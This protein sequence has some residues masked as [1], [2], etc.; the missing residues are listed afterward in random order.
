MVNPMMG[1][2]VFASNT[3][4]PMLTVIGSLMGHLVYGAAVGAVYETS[5][6]KSHVSV[7]T[8]Y[9]QRLKWMRIADTAWYWVCARSQTLR[10]RFG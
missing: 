3:P 2:G 6:V 9:T 8:N 10:K 5:V 1:A 4:A 7:S